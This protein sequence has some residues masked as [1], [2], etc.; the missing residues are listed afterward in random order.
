[1]TGYFMMRHAFTVDVEDW[2]DGIPISSESKRSSERRLH[3]GLER[4]LRLLAERDVRGTFFVLGPLASSHPELIRRIASEG[5]EV[6]CHG[7]SHDLLYT[8]TPDRF[9][10]E[11]IRARDG[12]SN[13][14]GTAVTAYRA[15]YF[16]ITRASFW[17]LEVLAS[18]GFRYDSSIFPVKNWRYGIPDFGAAPRRIETAA[19]PIHE[20]PLSIRRLGPL[21][22]PACGGAYFRIY[23]YAITRSNLRCA[24]RAG[25]PVVFYL[26]PWE[27]D[28]GH[29]RVA[30]YWKAQLTHY[31]NLGSTVPR[32]RRLLTDFSFGPLSEVLEHA[33]S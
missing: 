22:F 10:D 24:E 4:L 20:L 9:R 28:P 1:V 11:T 29:P 17:A 33:I 26:H 3:V 14:T 23:P 31:V 5:H 15:A 16:S 6:G 7:W 13:I 30:F 32:L 8:M 19:G 21:T 25:L 2:Y 12:I 27:L 18:L